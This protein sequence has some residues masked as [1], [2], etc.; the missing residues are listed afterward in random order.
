M[1]MALNTKIDGV[2]NVAGWVKNGQQRSGRDD[3]AKKQM[4]KYIVM[5]S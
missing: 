3:N 4:R 1:N 2:Y 5:I